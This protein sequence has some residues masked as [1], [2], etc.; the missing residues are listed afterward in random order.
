MTDL[1][2][3]AEAYDLTTRPWIMC[4]D[5]HGERRILSVRETFAQ[6]RE[7]LRIAGDSPQQ[8]LALLR[9]LL[10]VFWRAHRQDPRLA[11]G[12]PEEAAE[13]WGAQ[14]TGDEDAQ[15][16]QRIQSYLDK[17]APRWDLL[18]PSHPFM[19]VA[20][21]HTAKGEHSPVR[22]L[23]P[24]AESPYFTMRAGKG[25]ESLDFAEA[26][27]WL[28]HLQAW[29]YSG[30]KSGAV[31]DSRV[32][33][34]KGYPIGTGWS[35][36]GGGVILH[37]RNL[38]ETLTLNTVPHLVFGEQAER[39]LPVWERA[40]DGA[41]ARGVEHAMGPCDLLT[42]QIRRVRLFSSQGR[43]TGVLVANGDRLESQNEMSDPMTA[44]RLSGPQSKKAGR[45]VWMPRAH[46]ETRTLWRG[47]G[48]LLAQGEGA[49]AD[50]RPPS[51]VMELPHMAREAEDF[52]DEDPLVTVQLVG[53][54]YGTQDAVVVS[55]VDET[56]PLRLSILMRDKQ[57]AAPLITSTAEATMQVAIGLG[58]FAG[59][60]K[61]AA[62]GDYVFGADATEAFLTSLNE[63]FK[64]WL[65]ALT[66]ETDAT[67]YR[68]KWFKEAERVALEHARALASSVS[69]SAVIGREDDEGRLV[70]VATAR[71]HLECSFRKHFGSKA[72]G[73][74]TLAEK[75][76]ATS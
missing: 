1:H 72:Q 24:D 21:L 73:T 13:W 42:W 25:L 3:E 71:A 17:V 27:R 61:Q 45:D 57:R 28:V 12:S 63:P 31:G 9:L 19:Q 40:P 14:F 50:V 43:V 33:G 26:A 52:L 62:S 69:P 6:S 44:Y 66:P 48:P 5:V 11:D 68:A 8:D 20:D 10:V 23:I 54:V 15:A 18:H 2:D 65:A 41:G 53:T 30:I 37:G 49:K 74:K 46:S 7:V 75:G 35:G 67:E 47:I 38:A 36:R 22:K 64:A 34:G 70:S 29:N 51:T 59:V 16:G 60:L 55:T 4:L 76:M 32:K 56:M 58:Q 39:D